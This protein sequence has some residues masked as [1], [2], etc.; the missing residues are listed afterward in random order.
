[1]SE[2]TNLDHKRICDISIDARVIV[3]RRKDCITRVTANSN[4]TLSISHERVRQKPD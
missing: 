1:M 3:I 2:V 4:G